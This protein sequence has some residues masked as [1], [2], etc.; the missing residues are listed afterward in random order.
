M[1]YELHNSNKDFLIAKQFDMKEEVSF[2]MGCEHFHFILNI[3]KK[4]NI[5]CF[6]H[7]VIKF[8]SDLF[9]LLHFK[10]K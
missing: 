6:R 5:Q 4:F 3:I 10:I 8:E 9:N 7:F 1:E 2:K